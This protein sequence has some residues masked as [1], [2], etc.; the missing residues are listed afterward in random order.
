MA[1]AERLIF[2]GESGG[3]KLTWTTKDV[4]VRPAQASSRIVFSAKSMAEQEFKNDTMVEEGEAPPDCEA[5]RQFTLLSV[6]GPLISYLDEATM[7]CRGAAHA[8]HSVSF[9]TLNLSEPDPDGIS[10]SGL[11]QMRLDNLFTEADLLRGF[12]AEPIIKKT[13]EGAGMPPP[14]TL[15]N[16]DEQFLSSGILDV[17]SGVGFVAL[18][19]MSN[20][21]FHHLDQNSVAIR[22]CITPTSGPERGSF[23]QLGI[24][25]PTPQGLKQSLRQADSRQ[26]GF[27]MKDYKNVSGNQTTRIDF[28]SGDVST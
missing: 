6:V 10:S 20:F 28:T 2:T 22:I 12:L 7:S 25:L 16:L 15:R 13:I 23:S 11:K 26:A 8:M 21:A 27:L 19:P 9:R 4:V 1:D 5:G 3:F 24:L 17:N 14:R 18:E